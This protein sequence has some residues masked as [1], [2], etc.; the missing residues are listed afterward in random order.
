MNKSVLIFVA[1]VSI[2]LFRPHPDVRAQDPPT[3]KVESTY[4]Q[5]KDET[6]VEFRTLMLQETET[7]KVVLN[8]SA[9]YPGRKAKAPE[10]LIFV[11]QVLSTAGYRYPDTM[12]MRVS[13]EG[14]KL[15]DV[16]MINLDK[17]R[18]DE[19]YLESIGTRMQYDLFKQL[20]KLTSVQLEL[21]DLKLSMGQP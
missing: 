20:L 1:L 14:R 16:L 10:D 19:S 5:T 18:A 6:T 9:S 13:A 12:T 11:I 4:D 8:I 7:P 2:A 21:K 3:V 17:R 15:S